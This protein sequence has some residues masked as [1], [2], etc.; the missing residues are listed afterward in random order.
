MMVEFHE[1]LSEHSV[2]LRYFHLLNLSQRMAHERLTR[3]CFID[4]DR[5]MALVAERDLGPS[6]GSEILGI[7]RFTRTHG[8][9]DAEMAI[10]VSDDFHR[11]GL[12]TELLRRLL[13]IARR[14]K[15][16]RITADILAENRAMQRICEGLGF[17]LAYQAQDG[18]VKA[19]IRL[20][21]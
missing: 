13:E 15:V 18:T 5:E 17:R 14:E 20:N 9:N 10:L 21:H 12:G 7:G 2:Y 1:R 3:I 16:E 19:E 11:R 4:Y 6:G 8:T